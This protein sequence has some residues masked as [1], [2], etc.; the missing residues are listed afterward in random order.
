MGASSF[1]IDDGLYEVTFKNNNEEVFAKFSFNPSDTGL[2]SRY[3]S[4]IDFLDNYSMP[5]DA[6]I[7]EIIN[8]EE[9]IK[10]KIDELFNRE[11]SK[12]IFAVYNPCTIF[13]NGD[14]YIEVVIKHM[15]EIIEQE[16]DTRLKKKVAKI[17]KA[18][19][20]NRK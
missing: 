20:K 15:S 9:T 8:L 19:A 2:L 14:M 4:F 11:I 17:R 12:D 1:V 5:E 16:T 13:A 6:D 3:D 10:K 7:N 18:T